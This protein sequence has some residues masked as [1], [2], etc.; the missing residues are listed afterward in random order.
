MAT[1]IFKEILGKDFNKLDPILQR[2]YGNEEGFSASG[3]V[4]VTHGTGPI[5]KLMNK[6]L[7]LPPK[8]P[9]VKVSLNVKR[10]P[11]YE[12]WYRDFDGQILESEA[13]AKNGLLMEIFGNIT[14]GFKLTEEE[15]A[16]A[17]QQVFSQ[18]GKIKLPDW[19]NAKAVAINKATENG[20][21][22]EIESSYPVIGKLVRY[23]G[24]INLES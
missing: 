18:V 21:Y 7:K 3:I 2:A 22:I 5:I 12:Y 8:G 14:L 11:G 1:T 24:Q 16:L 23:E 19:L 4:N 9:Q 17:Y 15:G 10:N 6:T 13:Y 20:W